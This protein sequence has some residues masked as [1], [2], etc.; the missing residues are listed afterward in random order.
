MALQAQSRA[1]MQSVFDGLGAPPPLDAYL[2]KVQAR[3]SMVSAAA[4]HDEVVSQGVDPPPEVTDASAVLARVQQL[5][6]VIDTSV[7][8]NRAR[9]SPTRRFDLGSVV[10]SIARRGTEEDPS[11]QSDLRDREEMRSH[12]DKMIRLLSERGKRTNIALIL[13]DIGITPFEDDGAGT[14]HTGKARVTPPKKTHTVTASYSRQR[15]QPEASKKGATAARRGSRSRPPASVATS[16]APPGAQQSSQRQRHAQRGPRSYPEHSGR[17]AVSPSVDHSRRMPPA[18]P[19]A[20][21]EVAAVAHVPR[22]Q[23]PR[24]RGEHYGGSDNGSARGSTAAPTRATLLLPKDPTPR[25][26]HVPLATDVGQL[27]PDRP[28]GPAVVV[29]PEPDFDRS[30]RAP[31]P[32]SIF[33]VDGVVQSGPLDGATFEDARIEYVTR[34]LTAMLE[35]ELVGSLTDEML[36]LLSGDDRAQRQ[37]PPTPVVESSDESAPDAATPHAPRT[38]STFG[39]QTELAKEA[40]HALVGTADPM[41]DSSSEDRPRRSTSDAGTAVMSPIAGP[42]VVAETDP[43]DAI[44]QALQPHDIRQL[45]L[46]LAAEGAAAAP[47]VVDDP[48][49]EPTREHAAVGTTP[50]RQ[51]SSVGT[52]PRREPVPLTTTD[53][54]P[55]DETENPQGTPTPSPARP[56]IRA[57]LSPVEVDTEIL[58]TASGDATASD[59]EI[60]L[61]TDGEWHSDY[62]GGPGPYDDG[63]WSSRD[64]KSTAVY[65]YRHERQRAHDDHLS[66]G[67]IDMTGAGRFVRMPACGRTEATATESEAESIP[68]SLRDQ[69]VFPT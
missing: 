8:S 51:Q 68:E 14:G 7:V 21:P 42:P 53:E 46:A 48:R 69:G 56:P 22:G 10:D 55:A 59:G 35:R 1:S 47:V 36:P 66:D 25:P 24:R 45:L 18:H 64:D 33:G 32:P 28:A 31:L 65:L 23:P 12:V 44:R 4:H 27:A 19:T 17:W 57:P 52:S 37:A 6:N 29:Q 63:G 41:D 15:N 16:T 9:R 38:S 61:S 13:E 2:Q 50:R 30:A 3:S 39:T 11:G 58:G 26:V 5:K 54:E 40:N 34:K 62:S 60:L 67:Q 43:L 49:T 20:V